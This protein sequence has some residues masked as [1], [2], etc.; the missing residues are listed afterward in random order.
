M[1]WKWISFDFYYFKFQIFFLFL[2]Y[3]FLFHF[4]SIERKRYINKSASCLPTYL[5]AIILEYFRFPFLDINR[6]KRKPN[7]LLSLVFFVVVVDVCHIKWRKC[8]E[9]SEINYF[10]LF[11]GIWAERAQLQEEEV[12]IWNIKSCNIM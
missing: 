10:S 4:L 12:A 3:M 2:I 1:Y 11:V 5:I 6:H 9:K 7:Y 8:A